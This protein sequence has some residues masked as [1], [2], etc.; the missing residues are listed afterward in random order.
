MRRTSAILVA[1]V[2]TTALAL[3]ACGRDSGAESSGPTE[4]KAVSEGK[5]TGTISVDGTA[6]AGD[7][8]CAKVEDREYC[9]TTQEGDTLATIRDGMIAAINQDP[10]IEAYAASAFTRIR[11]RARI[12]GPAG[13]DRNLARR[14]G[15]SGHRRAVPASRGKP[16]QQRN[17]PV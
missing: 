9:Y 16:E 12:P 14:G 4:G 10:L 11:L 2:A 5:A 1:T 13:N 7:L 15:T 17:G 8:L 3:S 6:Q